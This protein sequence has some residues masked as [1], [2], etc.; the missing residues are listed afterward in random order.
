MYSVV[1]IIRP[2]E[3][4]DTLSGWYV[5]LQRLNPLAG[6][7]GKDVRKIPQMAEIQGRLAYVSSVWQLEEA[8]R[9]SGRFFLE[10]PVTQFGLLEFGK[11]Y[12]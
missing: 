6:W 2:V 4:G 3:F 8:K 5:M 7:I 1:I 10:P 11:Y 12:E 9:I